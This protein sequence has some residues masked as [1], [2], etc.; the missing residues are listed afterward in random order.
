MCV[1]YKVVLNGGCCDWP[2]LNRFH[3]HAKFPT[4]PYPASGQVESYP[5]VSDT[6]AANQSKAER[7]VRDWRSDK[8]VKRQVFSLRAQVE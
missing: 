4:L 6:V 7:G 8:N 5:C 3:V 2:Y 1:C